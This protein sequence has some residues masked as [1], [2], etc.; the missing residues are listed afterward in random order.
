MFVDAFAYLDGRGGKPLSE[1]NGPGP[2]MYRFQA[3]FLLE[4]INQ[5]FVSQLVCRT[6]STC[7]ANSLEVSG[8]K[9]FDPEAHGWK[10]IAREAP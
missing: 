1:P 6:V 2:L 5:L 3:C 10:T 9:P 7:F 4:V 8:S